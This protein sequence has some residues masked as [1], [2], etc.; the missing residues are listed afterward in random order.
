VKWID[1]HYRDE[2]M[3]LIPSAGTILFSKRWGAGL[4]LLVMVLLVIARSCAAAPPP[5]IADCPRTA[6]M[7]PALKIDHY[8]GP[9]PACVPDAITL[10]V[11]G[12]Q[13]L[14]AEEKPVLVDVWAILRRVE[15]GF[16]STWLPNDEHESLP[17]AV[18]L[19][20]VGYGTLEPDLEAYLKQNLERL[21]LGDKNKPL[22][23]FCVADCWMSWN[24][25]QRVRAYGYSRVYWFKDGTDGWA[26]K[27][28]E[29]VKVEPVKLE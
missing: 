15:E 6:D 26:E 24:T 29:L 4:A 16:G 8:R 23:F 10:D 19:P 25:V 28:L 3:A 9:T 27:G 7:P 14:L 11:A 17:A 22:V 12:L 21:T 2:T 1:P 20:N 5:G 18:W 13:T